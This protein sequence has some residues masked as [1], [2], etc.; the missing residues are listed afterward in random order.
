MMYQ[1][2]TYERR[3]DKR[4]NHTIAR[5]IDILIGHTVHNMTYAELAREYN[6]SRTRVPQIIAKLLRKCRESIK[7]TEEPRK[8]FVSGQV[9]VKED[10][11]YK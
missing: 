3:C 2:L 7:G 11:I 8:Y 1:M 9:Y 4:W 5:N 6:I 10:G